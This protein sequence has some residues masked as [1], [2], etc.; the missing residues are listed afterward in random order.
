MP[1]TVTPP[2][3]L[4]SCQQTRFHRSNTI[5]S[6][7]IDIRGLNVRVTSSAGEDISDRKG[8][9]KARAEEVEILVDAELKLKAGECYGLV[10]RN[11]SGKST[12]LRALAEG[13]IPGI[14]PTTKISILQQTSS[15]TT[16]NSIESSDEEQPKTVLQHVVE[17]D[18]SRNDI[19]RDISVLSQ[20]L[21]AAVGDTL[22]P[23][24][25]L[26]QM[27]HFRLRAELAEAE[28]NASLRSGS[29]GLQ[30][31]KALRVLEGR[32]KE[33]AE[34]VGQADE[35]ISEE[36]LQNEAR[37]AVDLLSD[38]QSQLEQMEPLPSVTS[39]ART[40]LSGLGFT[41]ATMSA[42]FHTLSGGWKMRC[43]LAGI[44]LQPATL[45]ILD[46]PTNFLDLHGI[47]WL[48]R[49]LLSLRTT[50][51]QKAILLVSHDRDFLDALCTTLIVLRDHT[52]AYFSGNLSAYEADQAAQKS[53]LTRMKEAQER[54]VSHM[55]KTIREG[56]R[57]GKKTGDEGKLKM[58]KSRQRRIDDRMGMQVGKGGG[59]FKLNRDLAGFHRTNR[60]AIET[61]PDEKII[62]IALPTPPPL[63]F[64]GPLISLERVTYTYPNAS[65]PSLKG[66]TLVIHPGDRIGIM[67]LNGGGKS[68]L[69]RVLRGDGVEGACAGVE[70]HPRLRLGYY[71][72]HAIE[73]LQRIGQADPSL[74]ALTHL[75]DQNPTTLTPPTARALLSTLNLHGPTVSAT[76]LSQ[77]SGGQLVR[78]AL[79]QIL[80]PHPTSCFWT[81]SPRI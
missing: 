47:I 35:E 2:N 15:T 67:G 57:M 26:R 36:T 37:E 11:G 38:L 59:R 18:A 49:H 16:T 12:I 56:I 9:A 46:E 78:V 5:V 39:Q 55:E 73:D 74:T 50:T 53:Y 43:L 70:R 52:L 23:V 81:K 7:G 20:S 75:V 51:P 71:G 79:A 65:K 72:Q 25:T 64:P 48:Q 66:L 14:P 34:L 61:P 21:D 32:F 54:Q 29:R 22:S 24:Y 6:S 41:P 3:I 44:L 62:N 30:A 68:T 13:L 31:R 33:S 60:A 76:P 77:L 4:V 58:A 80:H 1:D 40:I 69:L 63:R 8:K 10:G 45:L 28:K 27:R 17:S 19:L 42:A